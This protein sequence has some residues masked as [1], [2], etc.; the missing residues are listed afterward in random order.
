MR[1]WILSLSALLTSV[2]FAA[3]NDPFPE[4]AQQNPSKRPSIFWK[5]F[6]SYFLPGLGQYIDGQPTYGAAYTTSAVL[7]LSLVNA[8]KTEVKKEKDRAPGEPREDNFGYAILGYKMYDTAGSFSAYQSFRSAVRS[9][10]DD[11]SFLSKEE[12]LTS[13]ALAP[14]DFDHAMHPRVFIPLVLASVAAAFSRDM[15]DVTFTQPYAERF[16]STLGVS[17]GAGIGEEAIFRGWLMPISHYAFSSPHWANAFQ[18]TIFGL[19]HY[20]PQNKA[21]VFQTLAGGYLGWICQ[22]NGYSLRE[23]AFLHFWWDIIAIG[24]TYVLNTT[25]TEKKPMQLTLLNLPLP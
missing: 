18:A 9:R 1:S 23:S 24:N 12:S 10:K 13:I 22:S 5:Q 6:G 15:S 19:A 3:A 2:T 8:T 25:S 17:Y 14:F 20:G 21:P 4:Y 11:F 7:G 16:V